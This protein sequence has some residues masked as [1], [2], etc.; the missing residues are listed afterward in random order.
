MTV[1]L[2]EL[3]VPALEATVEHYNALLAEA[4]AVVRENNLKLTEVIVEL[5]R[6]KK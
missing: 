1:N 3:S 2:K 4:Y 6:R 5:N